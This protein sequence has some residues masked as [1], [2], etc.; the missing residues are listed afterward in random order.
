MINPSQMAKHHMDLVRNL[1]MRSSDSSQKQKTRSNE[2]SDRP[3]LTVSIDRRYEQ[4]MKINE[5]DTGIKTPADLVTDFDNL[6]L[7]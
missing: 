5:P 7:D 4:E 2:K 3:S 6:G 1:S